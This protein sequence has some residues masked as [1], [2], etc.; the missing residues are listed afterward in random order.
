M[1][2]KI[3]IVF[4]ALMLT[5]IISCSK[6]A[7]NIQYQSWDQV[8]LVIKD[9]DQSLTNKD[10]VFLIYSRTE[11]SKFN[12]CNDRGC[13]N[14]EHVYPKDLL[15]DS[16]G[17]HLS[18]AL[19]DLHNLRTSDWQLNQDKDNITIGPAPKGSPAGLYNGY[20]YPGDQ[21]RGDVARILMYM[22]YQYKD[23]GI[24]LETMIDPALALQWHREDP[25]DRF[26]RTRN[27]AIREIQGND[28]PFITNPSFARQI[29][30]TPIFLIWV[31]GTI[32]SFGLALLVKYLKSI[33][34]KQK[35]YEFIFILYIIFSIISG[36]IWNWWVM[37]LLFAGVIGLGIYMNQKEKRAKT[38]T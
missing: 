5:T 38:S 9:T 18:E 19:N 8:K 26:E 24:K 12:H 3:L 25:V 17:T 27:A 22:A 34:Y 35:F 13:W 30:G 14:I 29:Y 36:F 10:Y 37:L 28:N 11:S 4:L 2:K 31:I 16:N 6:P 15:R 32:L 20:W 7:T 23:S 1:R 21:D 33:Q